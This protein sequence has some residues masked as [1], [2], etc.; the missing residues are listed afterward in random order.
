MPSQSAPNRWAFSEMRAGAV[1]AAF[2][3]APTTSANWTTRKCVPCDAMVAGMKR[4][5]VWFA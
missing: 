1:F 2:N 5:G 3:C 4:A